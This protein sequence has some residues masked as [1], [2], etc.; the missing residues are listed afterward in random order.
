MQQ[1]Q[2][3][4][5]LPTLLSSTL[6]SEASGPH[7]Q[8]VR[9]ALEGHAIRRAG[10][11][12]SL[13]TVL[14]PAFLCT[15]DLSL[16]L[17]VNRPLIGLRALAPVTLNAAKRSQNLVSVSEVDLLLL[18]SSAPRPDVW[19]RSVCTGSGKDRTRQGSG[20][21][22]ALKRD[23]TF[24]P[25]AGLF[26]SG[27]GTR[28]GHR[29]CRWPGSWGAGG[30]CGPPRMAAG[31]AAARPPFREEATRGTEGCVNRPSRASRQPVQHRRPAARSSS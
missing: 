24:R 31:A 11:R 29:L 30:T 1:A 22:A 16:S 4:R 25:D 20:R 7:T 14:T 12:A 27:K 6:S 9:E 8:L 21:E 19:L 15:C 23:V 5:L 3:T 13:V 28:R 17:Y 2:Q 10:L 18:T 26:G